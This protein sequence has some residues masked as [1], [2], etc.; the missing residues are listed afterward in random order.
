MKE[1]NEEILLNINSRVIHI[2]AYICMGVWKIISTVF[3]T[4][5]ITIS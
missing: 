4:I 1:N 5:V 3:S 2:Y